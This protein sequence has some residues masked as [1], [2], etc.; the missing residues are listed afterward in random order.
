[1][2]VSFVHNSGNFFID[3]IL[4]LLTEFPHKIRLSASISEDALT[5]SHVL[6]FV[7]HTV[8]GNHSL[9]NVSCLGNVV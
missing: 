6:E 9:D 5:Q 8:V 1:M 3:E 7:A 2:I 4:S